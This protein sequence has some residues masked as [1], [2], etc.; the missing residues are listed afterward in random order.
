VTTRTGGGGGYGE[1]HKRRRELVEAD[2]RDGAISTETARRV[3][4][5]E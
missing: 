2:L 3:Y 4:G 1:P 5:Y